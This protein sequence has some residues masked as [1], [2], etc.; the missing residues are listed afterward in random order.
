MNAAELDTATRL[1]C[2]FTTVV[3]V[4]DE[5]RLITE[6]FEELVGDTYGTELTNPE[7]VTFAES[8]GIEAHEVAS[9]DDLQG[10][11]DDALASDDLTLLAVPVQYD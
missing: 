11:L 8:F 2:S 1:D 7:F 6:E 4:D 3:F 9:Y 10:R 5:Y